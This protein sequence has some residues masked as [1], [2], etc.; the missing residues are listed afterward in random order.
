M[1]RTVPAARI[2]PN[3][4]CSEHKKG[5]PWFGARL[6]VLAQ[7][8]CDHAP[9]CLVCALSMEAA[10][11][12]F[13]GTTLLAKALGGGA[14]GTRIHVLQVSHARFFFGFLAVLIVVRMLPRQ[15]VAARSRAGLG[16]AGRHRGVQCLARLGDRD[17]RADRGLGRVDHGLAR[18]PPAPG[19]AHTVSARFPRCVVAPRHATPTPMRLTRITVICC[20]TR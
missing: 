6:A 13:A 11:A 1:A 3:P 12:F 16:G 7:T 19:A 8:G 2:A 5:A 15:T 18:K 17:R 10:T 14:T 20:I 4:E 9:S